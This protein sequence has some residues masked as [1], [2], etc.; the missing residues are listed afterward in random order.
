MPSLVKK[1]QSI[2]KELDEEEKSS[3]S[4]EDR[5]QL[6]KKNIEEWKQQQLLTYVCHREHIWCFILMELKHRCSPPLNEMIMFNFIFFFMTLQ[7]ESVKECQL[8]GCA[9]WL[10]ESTKEA[11]AYE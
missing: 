5:D 7:R 2:Q 10:A 8:W 4:D 11:E 1:W 9:W 3:S 6:A